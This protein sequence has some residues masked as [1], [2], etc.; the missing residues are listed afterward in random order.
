MR[1]TLLYL[2]IL[3]VLGFGVWFF[4]FRGDNPFGSSGTN[5]TIRDTGSI[6]KIFIADNSGKHAT[7]SRGDDGWLVDQKY[8]AIEKTVQELLNTFYF[9]EV[10]SPVPSKSRN[11]VIKSLAG[12]AIKCEVYNKDGHLMRRFYVGIETQNFTGTYMLMDGADEAYIVQVPGFEGYLQ[13]RYNPD[14]AGW[15][16][17][18]VVDLAPE[19]IKGLEMNYPLQPVNNFSLAWNGSDSNSVTVS[20]PPEMNYGSKTPV[21]QKVIAYLKF[22]QGV[23]G[24]AFL[25]GNKNMDTVLAHVPLKASIRLT[26]SSGAEENLLLYYTPLNRRS[27]NL[28]DSSSEFENQ[29]DSDH[30]YAVAHGGK[31]TMLVQRRIFDK[32]LRR[33]YEFYQ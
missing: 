18:V 17:R 1:K 28:E 10:G 29:W 9:Q 14:P 25:N 6:G 23:F 33:G 4:L 12:N 21:R 3:A 22:Y 24:E 15:R 8:P 26:T 20:L 19:K 16:S 7:L 30:Y 5:F 31:D 13:P 27:K 2:F 32:L 11:D